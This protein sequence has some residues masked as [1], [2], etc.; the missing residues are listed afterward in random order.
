MLNRDCLFLSG[1]GGL[2]MK[3]V[4]HCDRWMHT[5]SPSKLVYENGILRRNLYPREDLKAVIVYADM[6]DKI[7]EL[8]NL[9]NIKK[10]NTPCWPNI[11]SLIWMQSR[12]RMMWMCIQEKLCDNV[13][14]IKFEDKH[15]VTREYPFVLKVGDS[16]RGQDKFLIENDD[17]WRQF[18]WDDEAI[19]ER[20]YHGDSTRALVIGDDVVGI[21]IDNDRSWIK[22][23]SGAEVSTIQ[24]SPQIIDHAKRCVKVFGLDLAGI[25]YIVKNTGEFNLLEVN[26]FP[27]LSNISD[28]VD[29]CVEKFLNKKMNQLQNVD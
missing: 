2:T 1:E 4:F 29:V 9:K 3:C 18:T 6:N 26:Q 12:A 27:G 15:Q 22:N 10:S 20:F 5:C 19:I 23:T 7:T 25:D 13:D 21:K 16:H 24:L 8:E 17:V 28:E 11:D 14:I